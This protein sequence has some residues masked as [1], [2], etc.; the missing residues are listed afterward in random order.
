MTHQS[1]INRNLCQKLQNHDQLADTT[2]FVTISLQL[3]QR[4]E[5]EQF[6]AKP[7]TDPEPTNISA[8]KQQQQ[9]NRINASLNLQAKLT[10]KLRIK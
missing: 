9:K 7:P 3:F 8:R 4:V 2:N 6:W 10:R 1:T 5:F